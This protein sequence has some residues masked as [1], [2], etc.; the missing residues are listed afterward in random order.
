M[1]SALDISLLTPNSIGNFLPWVVHMCDTVSPSVKHNTLE[2]GNHI[3]ISLSSVLDLRH[4]DPKFY[5]EH[6]PPMGSLYV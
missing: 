1:S 4:F 2:P 6:L 5:K 3:S